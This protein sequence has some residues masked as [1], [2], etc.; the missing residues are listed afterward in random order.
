M[1]L[2]VS[3]DSEADNAAFKAKYDFPFDLL[4]DESKAMS[5]AYGAA[6]SV[7]DARAKRI[8]YILN[9]EGKVA[10]VYASVKPAD[11]PQQVLGD[12]AT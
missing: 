5:V 2:G 10:M 6:D 3:T 1:I 8:S 11:H 7:D 4:C 12:L 9:G